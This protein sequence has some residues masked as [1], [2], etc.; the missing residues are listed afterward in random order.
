M[1]CRVVIGSS[2]LEDEASDD[3]GTMEA[4]ME[5]ERA[6][7][8]AE[9]VVRMVVRAFYDHEA[10]IVLDG[11]LYLSKNNSVRDQVVLGRKRV[12]TPAP[13]PF[14]ASDQTHVP[15]GPSL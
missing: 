10:V 8:L 4:K 2:R 12:S 6:L 1:Q 13:A 7:K 5:G 9:D 11:L 15:A 14:A 3:I